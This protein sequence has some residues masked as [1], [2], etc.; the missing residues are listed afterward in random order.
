MPSN[1]L[2]FNSVHQQDFA[3]VCDDVNLNLSMG[4]YCKHECQL[5]SL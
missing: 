3:Y 4:Y 5:F 1:Y 2:S